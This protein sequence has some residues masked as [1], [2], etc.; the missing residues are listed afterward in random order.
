MSAGSCTRVVGGERAR[1]YETLL[2]ALA[3]DLVELCGYR[4]RDCY[5]GSG[6]PARL[7]DGN[8]GAAADASGAEAG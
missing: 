1:A 5:L 4:E 2:S 6:R 7:F 3:A 8:L